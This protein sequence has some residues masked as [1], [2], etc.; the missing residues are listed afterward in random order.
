M[1]CAVVVSIPS[2]ARAADADNSGNNTV[3]RSSDAKTP[4]SQS[5]EQADVDVTR[6]IRRAIV[7]DSSLSVYGHNVKIITTKEHAVYLSGAVPSKGE[8]TK[9][10]DL[11][12]Q[13]SAGYPVKCQLSVSNK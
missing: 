10:T 8:V 13:N 12:Q 1:I 6:A 4:E 2:P 11:A 7:K 5:N 3:D 9:I